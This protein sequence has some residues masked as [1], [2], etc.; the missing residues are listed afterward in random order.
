MSNLARISIETQSS[1]LRSA[2]CPTSSLTAAPVTRLEER[3]TDSLRYL[4][5]HAPVHLWQVGEE[6]WRGRSLLFTGAQ[7]GT[8]RAWAL[9]SDYRLRRASEPFLVGEG[10]TNLGKIQP[11]PNHEIKIIVRGV[12]ESNLDDSGYLTILAE[13]VPQGNASDQTQIVDGG[14]EG[15]LGLIDGGHKLSLWYH[16]PD[17]SILIAESE[18]FEVPE[19]TEFVW[20]IPAAAFD[21]A[22]ESSFTGESR[23]STRRALKG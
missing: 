6:S 16:S 20:Q 10:R 21:A 15:T 8:H 14:F 4:W 1:G 13:R 9:D 19:T 17:G 7:A 11:Q 2:A 23:V 12:L 5:N 22:D 18:R 3:W